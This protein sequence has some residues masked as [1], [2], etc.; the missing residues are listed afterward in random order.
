ML[1]CLDLLQCPSVSTADFNW[2][3]ILRFHMEVSTVLHA[4]PQS[5]AGDIISSDSGVKFCCSTVV[6]CRTSECWMKFSLVQ[7]K[8]EGR[9]T[10]KNESCNSCGNS[11]SD[12]ISHLL[13]T[14]CQYFKYQLIVN[15]CSCPPSWIFRM[16]Y[17]IYLCMPHNGIPHHFASCIVIVQI[18]AEIIVIYWVF[19]VVVICH[20][21]YDP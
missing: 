18:I 15:L 16:P 14:Q 4:L 3:S 10:N 8:T 1:L 11:W 2:Q 17:F 20:I 12:N 7:F 5:L 6:C 19:E 21:G 13:L 9:L